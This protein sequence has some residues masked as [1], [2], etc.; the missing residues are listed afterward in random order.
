MFFLLFFL[1]TSIRTERRW[2]QEPKSLRT[3]SFSSWRG[4]A[5]W[6][7]REKPWASSFSR[8]ERSTTAALP[9]GRWAN[10]WLTV[11]QWTSVKAMYS[12]KSQLPK[13]SSSFWKHSLAHS[14]CHFHIRYLVSFLTLCVKLSE[15]ACKIVSVPSH[16]GEGVCSGEPG[17]PAQP[18][19]VS[20]VW[21]AAQWQE[22]HATDAPEGT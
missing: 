14:L 9:R 3:W 22:P 4:R 6:R 8:R 17:R 15:L 21:T 2:R 12:V 20:G 13:K 1:L 10:T 5:A 11:L 19:G 16:S 7:R 18:A